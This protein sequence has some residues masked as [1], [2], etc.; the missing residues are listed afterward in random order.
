MD[1][2]T[3]EQKAKDKPSFAINEEPPID[4][5][6]QKCLTY[7]TRALD[8]VGE[9]PQSLLRAL[10][11]ISHSDNNVNKLYEP[12]EDGRGVMITLKNNNKEVAAHELVSHGDG[13][14]L[15][16][17]EVML[18]T[19]VSIDQ[20]NRDKIPSPAPNDEQ[21]SILVR[22]FTK[23]ATLLADGI[24]HSAE[25]VMPSGGVLT[26]SPA[27]ES[28]QSSQDQVQMPNKD[29]TIEISCQTCGSDTRAEAGARAFVR[30]PV[31]LSIVLC[32]NRLSSQREIDEVLVHELIHIYDVHSRK[33]DLRDCR[34]LAHSE[35]RAAREAECS[36]SFAQ[37]TA[38]ICVKDKATVATR[39]M[40]P[41]EGKKCVCDVF[42]E[43][44]NDLAPFEEDGRNNASA[45]AGCIKGNDTSSP[46][47]SPTFAST[48]WSD[49]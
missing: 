18:G 41:E 15:Q 19:E 34:Q 22:R 35:V 47:Q 48:R 31:P 40:F 9:R 37:F 27:A 26:T 13:S 29:V 30:G 25:D 3:T 14:Q 42:N 49:R 11:V 8:R 46:V 4:R 33:M 21:H 7:L 5:D 45:K 32:S 2:G 6:C 43:A 20:G 23:A 28:T 12:T 10:G 44:M 16:R 39:N 24:R 36:N 38:N 1:M 17:R